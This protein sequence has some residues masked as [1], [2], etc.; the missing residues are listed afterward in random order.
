MTWAAL[1][2]AV[3]EVIWPRS[4]RR[5][6]SIQAKKPSTTQRRG[7]T[8]RPTRSPNFRTTRI[9]VAFATFL[10]GIN[11][12]GRHL[13]DRGKPGLGGFAALRCSIAVLKRARLHLRFEATAVC[14][15]KSVAT[16]A[17]ESHPH[18][19]LDPYVGPYAYTAP[20]VVSSL[21]YKR[22]QR[23]NRSGL[24]GTASR[25]LGGSDHPRIRHQLGRDLLGAIIITWNRRSRWP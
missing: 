19:L 2:R 9:A 20:D 1:R 4:G 12:F 11:A 15:H 24:A 3:A 8:W 25:R 10:A 18:A 14:I 23:A 13:L 5:L 6:L 16:R 21:T 22:R 17:A 7:K